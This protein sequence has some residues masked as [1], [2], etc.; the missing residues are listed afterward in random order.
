MDNRV[1]ITNAFVETK[2]FAFEKY[3]R[4]SNIRYVD[5]ISSIDYVAYKAMTGCSSS[6]I[7][8]LKL[9]MHAILCGNV[10]ISPY[11]NSCNDI[12]NYES[13][14]VTF[15][16]DSEDTAIVST[17]K[18]HD[19]EI[20]IPDETVSKKERVVLP[21][22][23][24][25]SSP[26]EVLGLSVRCINALKSAEIAVIA[27]I[28]EMEEETLFGIKNLGSKSV[29]E[30]MKVVSTLRERFG[31]NGDYSSNPVVYSAQ[32]IS[33]SV[34]L[35]IVDMLLSGVIPNPDELQISDDEKN[36]IF[37]A[38]EGLETIGQ[39]FA[40][41]AYSNPEKIRPFINM[42]TEYLVSSEKVTE[43]KRNYQ[44]I[45]KRRMENQLIYYQKAIL[46]SGSS[47]KSNVIE[48]LT[49]HIATVA[50]LQKILSSTCESRDLKASME[51]L[52]GFLK[53]DYVEQI[54]RTISS[55][56]SSVKSTYGLYIVEQRCAGVTLQTLADELGLTRERIR[57][58][59]AKIV[60]QIAHKIDGIGFDPLMIV[61]A[62]R[63]GDTFL[64]YDEVTEYYE[65]VDNKT[66]MM[67][68]LVDRDIYKSEFFAYDE[69]LE[70]FVMIAAKENV[71][72]VAQIV[73]D[74]PM[75]I[76]A[77]Q[78]ET[79]LNGICKT[80]SILREMLDKEFV[81][82][83]KLSGSIYYKGRLSLVEI[84][85]YIME[86]H[87][88]AGIKLYDAQEI[89]RL[90]A[91]I[92]SLFGDIALPENNR[93]IDARIADISVLC[94]RGMYINPCHVRVEQSLI[95][96]IFN[97]ICN[98][99]RA[100][101]SFNELFETFKHKLLQ[102]SNVSN[103]YFLQGVL[104]YHSRSNLF[105]SK[106]I[107]SKEKGAGLGAEIETFIQEKGVIHKAEIFL[108]FPGVTEIMLS[109]KTN[110]AE[111]I[112]ILDNG[113]YMHADL[114][115]IRETDYS[116]KDIIWQNTQVVPISSRKLL[117][118]LW[119]THTDFLSRNDISDHSKLFGVVRYMFPDDFSF[120]RPFIARPGTEELTNLSVIKRHLSDYEDISL[121]DML[122]ICSENQLRFLSVRELVRGLS[123]EF[124]R[125][126]ADMLSRY[127]VAAFDDKTLMDIVGTLESFMQKRNCIVASKIKD[128]IF[129]PEIPFSWNAFI[130]RGIV[131]RY[132]NDEIG[133]IDMPTT[134]TYA[135]NT[136]FIDMAL[137][138]DSYEELLI[139]M[140]RC[141]HQSEPF[142]SVNEAV[143][144]LGQEG[145][146]NGDPPKCLLDG[147]VVNK[148]EY[149]QIQIG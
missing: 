110:A 70:A 46:E 127:D 132:L 43:L 25:L 103:R 51:W 78:V 87:Y 9:H 19:A 74:L 68:I 125:I 138:I 124:L 3:C 26:I 120:S 63:N 108:A 84:Y 61:C 95:D 54:S 147:S 149:G 80:E 86:K 66:I 114:L 45:P 56:L 134:D 107:I 145:F 62:E 21:D 57:Q 69:T 144:W 82:K 29:T 96:E 121:S 129:F 111:N 79:V 77:A 58:I 30:I 18:P 60:R 2:Y 27:Q 101:F 99:E 52:L 83:Y 8:D 109:M 112:V 76:P 148:D 139:L 85:K 35:I 100:V 16:E 6:D 44:C 36:T 31:D 90:R 92:S 98:S 24:S 143:E 130:L 15:S 50:E 28:I 49:Q 13:S 17:L 67:S 11:N 119:T 113:R 97:Y 81:I 93:A 136:I 94:D 14:T 12:C 1:L 106:D 33:S 122:G 37:E 126:D 39:E 72:K 105:F 140:L 23:I 42:F 34:R 117:E 55:V 133:L 48:P 41:E 75:F 65:E 20:Q 91:H 131:E 40:F 73:A 4:E 115:D 135:M 59:E 7:E 104:K 38:I 22:I 47:S 116:I 64:S 142:R 123:D 32:A 146:Y 10:F 53:I 118:Q 89:S 128:Y 102:S 88:P 137:D 141:E 71:I 5:E